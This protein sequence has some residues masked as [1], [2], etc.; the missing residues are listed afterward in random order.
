MARLII[1]S[2]TPQVREFELKQG[3]NHLGRGEANDF[4]IHDDSVSNHHAQ[5][6][7]DGSF[8]VIK[9]L[10]STNGTFINQSQVNV[11][12]LQPGQSLRLG[13]VDLIFQAD[14]SA[15][16]V[17]QTDV[18]SAAPVPAPAGGG[19]R[20]FGSHSAAAP[21]PPPPMPEQ[22]AAA[23]ALALTNTVELAEPPPG[24]TACKF[25]PKISGQ[26]LCRKCNELFCSVCV[27]AKATGEGIVHSCRKCGTACVPVKAKPVASKEKQVVVYSNKML[28]IRSLGFGFGAALLGALIWTGLS[29]LMG[30]D[31]P[32]IF[33]PMVGALCGY[34]VKLGCQDT[35]SPVFS[36]IAVV[37][38]IIGSVIG[39]LGMIAVTH[40]TINTNTTYFTGGLGICLAI[41]AAWKIGGDS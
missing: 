29:Y 32:F 1:Y 7:V 16:A 18:S 39:K 34:A 11:G 13:G 41:Y 9:D 12:V 19:L 30:V 37:C 23:A 40:L 5:I 8:V 36:A 21:P 22:P 24:K 26:W 2:G 6:T 15:D 38:C 3:A 31:V 20:L 14:A 25:H 10:N 17:I 33:A 27:S 28:L 4:Q 35:P